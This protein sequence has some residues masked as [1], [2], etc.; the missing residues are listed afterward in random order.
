MFLNS[1][2]HTHVTRIHYLYPDLPG[3]S[4]THT[5]THRIAVCGFEAYIG[6]KH[7]VGELKRKEKARK[8]ETSERASGEL[9]GIEETNPHLSVFTIG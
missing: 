6:G 5:K 2:A 8:E 9:G 4:P 7:V 1:C 3:E